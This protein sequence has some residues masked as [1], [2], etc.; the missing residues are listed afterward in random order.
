MKIEPIAV[1]VMIEKRDFHLEQ[2]RLYQTILGQQKHIQDLEA[3]ALPEKKRIDLN[4][5]IQK[6]IEGILASRLLCGKNGDN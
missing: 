3:A 5:E 1:E 4:E 2:F 6:T